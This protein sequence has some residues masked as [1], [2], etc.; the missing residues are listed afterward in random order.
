MKSRPEAIFERELL[1]A[2]GKVPDLLILKNE[3]GVGYRGSLRNALESVL[4]PFGREVVEAAEAV[5]QRHRITYGLGVGSP[6]LALVIGP[7]RRAAG[8]ELKAGD[9]DLSDEQRR[10]HAAAHRRGVPCGVASTI[11]EAFDFF[12]RARKGR[13][14]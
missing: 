3:V 12:E 14:K 7:Q 4:T 1:R 6:D 5:L 8:L 13:L 10:Y 11:D 9:N 2:A